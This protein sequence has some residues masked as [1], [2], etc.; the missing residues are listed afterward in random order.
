MFRVLVALTEYLVASKPIKRWK[1]HTLPLYWDACDDESMI[2]MPPSRK[3]KKRIY[4]YTCFAI[5]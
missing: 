1:L 5:V 3:C 4:E 2:S